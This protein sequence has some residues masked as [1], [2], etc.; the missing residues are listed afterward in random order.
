MALGPRQDADLS[1]R[2]QSTRRWLL[3]YHTAILVGCTMI[4]MAALALHVRGQHEV[5]VPVINRPLPGVCTFHRLTGY[6]CPGCGLTRSVISA[7]HGHWYKALVFNAAGLLFFALILFQ[8]PYR[9]LQI[10]RI[11]RQQEAYYFARL[12]QWVVLA[13]AIVLLLQWLVKLAWH[14]S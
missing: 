8:L 13:L 5:V 7:A 14:M 9:S 2:E 10:V 3:E 6:D 12:D 1:Q 11:Y 4:I